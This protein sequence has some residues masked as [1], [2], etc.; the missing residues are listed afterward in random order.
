MAILDDIKQALRIS[1]GITAFD[2]GELN[3]LI[4][5]ALA[6][7]GLAGVASDKAVTTDYMVKQAVKEYCKAMFGFDNPEAA[8]FMQNY[9]SIKTR[10]AMSLDHNTYQV[11][12]TVK[13]AE[14]VVIPD[15][16]ITATV[17]GENT[18][19]LTN[20]LGQATLYLYG[21][22]VDV[23]YVVGKSGYTTVTGSVWVDASEAMAVT[24]T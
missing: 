11:V 6:D 8:R 16:Y 12:W 21:R 18:A 19:L 10:L 24:L 22:Y 4:N 3:D 9:E 5:A 13:T 17:N 7:L 23:D 20:S 2:A 14:A 15:V 1:T